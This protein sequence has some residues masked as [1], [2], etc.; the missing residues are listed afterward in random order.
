MAGRPIGRR[1]IPLTV[2]AALVVGLPLPGLT[3]ALRPTALG[4]AGRWRGGLPLRH[5]ARGRFGFDLVIRAI[6]L[7]VEVAGGLV[8]PRHQPIRAD[9]EFALA[10]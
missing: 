1:I 5:I 2:L 3:L 9:H 6:R 4:L 8:K 7:Q 10:A